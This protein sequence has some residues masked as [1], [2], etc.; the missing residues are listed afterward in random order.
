MSKT[1][2]ISGG[3]N[4]GT[5]EAKPVLLW[6]DTV[7]YQSDVDLLQDGEWLND[8]I[9]SFQYDW[10]EKVAFSNSQKVLFMRPSMVA[11]LT[12]SVESPEELQGV[13]PP[14]LDKRAWIWMPINDGSAVAGGGSHWSLLVWHAGSRTFYYF[15]SLANGNQKYAQETADR[16]TPLLIQVRMMPFFE[17]MPTP[18]QTN[19]SDC[20]VYVCAITSYLARHHLLP[21]ISDDQKLK[22]RDFAESV[23]QDPQ[24]QNINAA[25]VAETR[26][27]MLE[28]IEKL[29]ATQLS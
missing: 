15:D 6:D 11:L 20:G 13:L 10:L 5:E 16:I 9:I 19:G 12:Q 21:A 2:P 8:A 14:D 24:L 17:T 18:Q 23:V 28:T 29:A 1:I 22:S 3:K 4:D 7:L 27:S 26:R 25:T